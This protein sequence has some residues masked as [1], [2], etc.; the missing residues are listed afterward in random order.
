[1]AELYYSNRNLAYTYN[2]SVATVYNWIDAAKNGKLDLE[3]Y[4]HG[5]KAYVRKNTR[6][7]AILERLAK[8]RKKYRPRQAVKEVTPRP[9]FYKIYNEGQIYDI[10]VN[11]EKHHEVDVEYNYFDR[12][13]D[14]WDQTIQRLD[15]DATPYY[16]GATELL[17]L[18]SAYLDNL[19][20]MY[21]RINIVDIG[22]GNAIPARKLIQHILEL[23][24][25]G[26]YIALDISPKMLQIAK[27]NISEWFNNRVT[28]EDYQLDITRERFSHILAE[29]YLKNE[30][31]ANIVLFLGGTPNNFRIPDDS[32]RVIQESLRK[33]DLFI[34][35]SK[36]DTKNTRSF[37]DLKFNILLDPVASFIF[38][39]LNIDSSLYE[40][41][42]GYDETLRQRYLRIRLT[43]AIR[44]NFD[45]SFGK[46]VLEFDKGDRILFWRAWQMTPT[47]IY[48][49]LERN[50]FYMLHST[51][52]PDKQFIL[53]VSQIQS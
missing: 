34:R 13:A 14:I 27:R 11:L 50:G 52:T 43:A 41:E 26:R 19:L 32:F 17:G 16:G 23:N 46:Q 35:T 48:A 5:E 31:V 10:V 1:V 42:K 45:F 12:G 39:L 9:E 25:L 37:I 4:E 38:D 28:F 22:V 3:L 6:N 44:M 53:T 36:L 20:K 49:Q 7:I 24:K 8:E 47:D 30:R 29:D 40:V 2:V 15:A 21:D 51:Q 18:S 33:D